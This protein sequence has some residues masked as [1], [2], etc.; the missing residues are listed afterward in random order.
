[1]A[2]A[3]HHACNDAPESPDELYPWIK[4]IHIFSHRG[5]PM[6]ALRVPRPGAERSWWLREAMAAEGEPPPEP[7]LSGNVDA[8]VAIVGGGY[9]GMWA[10]WFLAERAP[11]ARIVL[12]E[13]DICGGGPSGRNGGF[14]HGWWEN[15]PELARR[16]GPDAAAET[17]RAADEVVGGIGAW[18]ET[19]GVDAWFTPAGYLRV[20]AFGSEPSDWAA[21]VAQLAELGAGGELEPRSEAE[22]QAVCASP[23]FRDGVFMRSA[24]SIQPARLARGLRRALLER[25]VRIFEETRVERMRD[26]PAAVRLETANGTVRAGQAILGLNAWAAG[27]P[28]FRLRTLAWGSYMVVTEPIPDRLAEIGWTG[29]ELLSDS[30]FTISYF[31][32]TRDGRIAFGAG[33]RCRRIRRSHRRRLH[34]RRR[35]DRTRRLQFPSSA[36]DALGCSLRGVVGRP[37]RHHRR[38]IPGD[39]LA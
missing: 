30:R 15:L 25:G 28:G 9:T 21:T 34:A 27:W 31:R 14:V 10:A 23:A 33:R 22:V 36:A 13:Q 3:Y 18:C 35:R 1:M 17:A 2:A 7:P 32:T 6:T 8:D 38:S 39:R 20:N 19:N 4:T 12:L 24:A 29:G 11:D 37:D 16:Y 5:G 26:D